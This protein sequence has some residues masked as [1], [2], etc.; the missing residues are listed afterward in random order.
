MRENKTSQ[1]YEKNYLTPSQREELLKYVK[2][3]HEIPHKFAY[4]N[5]GAKVWDSVSNDYDY[6]LG[7]RELSTLREFMQLVSAEL[8]SNPFNILHIGSGNGIEIPIIIDT[9]GIQRI[10]YYALIDIGSELLEMAKSYGNKQCKSLKYLSFVHDMTQPGI[11]EIAKNLKRNGASIN[12]FLLIGN[13]AILSNNQV[14][15]YVKETMNPEDRLLITLEIYSTDREKK[16]LEQYRLPSIINLFA[17]QLS[18]IGINDHTP[19]QFEFVYDK[20]KSMIEIYFFAKEWIKEHPNENLKIEVTLPDK[21]KVFSSL[22]PTPNKL[23]EILTKKGFHIELF[24]FFEAEQC[25]GILCSVPETRKP[26]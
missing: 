22:R 12:L 4:F 17:Q 14:L 2:R 24:H 16:I 3:K 7:K 20:G 23:K 21:I 18:L 25:C 10:G 6:D 15:T 19:E 11:S 9:L 8:K 5:T 13:G 1:I 26:L